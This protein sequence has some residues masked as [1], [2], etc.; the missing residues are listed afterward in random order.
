[1]HVVIVGNGIAGVTAARHVRKLSSKATITLVSGETK[2]PYSRTALMYIYMGTLTQ[3]HTWLY[4]ERFWDENRIDRMS[5]HARGLD[6]TRKVLDLDGC[7]LAYDRLLIASGSVPFIPP[8]PGHQLEGVQGLYHLGD[9]ER[10]ETATPQFEHGVV[11]G[12]GLIGVELAEMLRVRGKEVT[13]LVREERYMP[14]ILVEEESAL[15]ADAIRQHGVDLRLGTEVERIEGATQVEAVV[16][17]GGDRVEAGVVGVGTGV[18]PNVSWLDGSG[19]DLNRGVLV[20]DTLQTSDPHVF[21]AGDCAQLRQPPS[22]E[23]PTR[24]IW[25]TARLQGATAAFGLA[26]QPRVYAPGVFFN[27]AKFFDLEYQT[28]GTATGEPPP[29]EANWLVSDG[30]RSIRIQHRTDASQAVVGVASLGVRLR[31]D[32]CSRWVA[33]GVALADARRQLELADFDPEFTQRLI[34]V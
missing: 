5:D 22:A 28:Y 25:Y 21:A 13:F 19:L 9:L 18:R 7:E 12:G 11:V 30:R 8:W 10:L 33:E 32:V 24:P 23:P 29:G 14:L 20:T 17:S 2:E 15:V 27:S 3:Q 6:T 34:A 4:E 16:T 26:G 31:Q 1:M